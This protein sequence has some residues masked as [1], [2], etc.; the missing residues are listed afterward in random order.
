MLEIFISSYK[1]V[2]VERAGGVTDCVSG[3]FAGS[4]WLGTSP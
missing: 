1:E 4:D 3:G 2:N